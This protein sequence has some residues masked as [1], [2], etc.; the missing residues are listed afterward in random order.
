MSGDRIQQLVEKTFSLSKD[1]RHHYVTIEHLLAIILDT[2]EIQDIFA[3]I[4]VDVKEVSREIYG[5]LEKEVEAWEAARVQSER[6]WEQGVSERARA[7]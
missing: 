5:H 7:Y 1:Y 4:A 3:E 6:A 2:E